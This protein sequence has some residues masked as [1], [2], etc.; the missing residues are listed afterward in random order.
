[1]TFTPSAIT[2]QIDQSQLIALMRSA[3]LRLFDLDHTNEAADKLGEL[4][5]ALG[6]YAAEVGRP[7]YSHDSGEISYAQE[8]WTGCDLPEGLA[9]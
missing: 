7:D 6:E 9:A 8:L 2:A 3:T 4:E 1:M 5:G